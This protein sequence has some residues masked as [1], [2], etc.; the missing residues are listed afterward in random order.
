MNFCRIAFAALVCAVLFLQQSP[1]AHCWGTE[2]HSIVA[3]LAQSRLTNQSLQWIAF[4][5]GNT[6]VTL[7][8]ICAEADSY[9]Q[10]SAG[11]WSADLHYLNVAFLAPTIELSRDCG[12][13]VGFQCVVA[14]IVNYSTILEDQVVTGRPNSRNKLWFPQRSEDSYPEPS[15]LAFVTHFVGDVHQPLHVSFQC[16]EGGNDVNT[17]QKWMNN[18]EEYDN[19][20]KIWDTIILETYSENTDTWI[21]HLQSQIDAN[22]GLVTQALVNFS[23][24]TWAEESYNMTRTYAYW[25]D[26]P[27]TPTSE[28]LNQLHYPSGNKCPLSDTIELSTAYLQNALPVV[29]SR[30]LKAGVRL[31]ELLNSIFATKPAPPFFPPSL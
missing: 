8:D 25:F 23:P 26:I 30:L 27:E 22:P 9:D 21:A 7:I 4:L 24:V 18:E 1:V 11:A 16:D 13:S 20:H 12:P 15:P 3:G 17:E 29:N 5:T 28:Q 10:T 14:A 19:L 31:A 6:S 2:G